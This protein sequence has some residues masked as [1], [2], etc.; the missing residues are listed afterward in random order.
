MVVV[1]LVGSAR[2]IVPVGVALLAML[3][4]ARVMVHPGMVDAIAV[5]AADSVAGGWPLLAPAVGALAADAPRV[6][7][8]M[9]TAAESTPTAAV[10]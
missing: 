5:A 6:G 3:G 9:A 1:V 2:T 4:L 7:R 10:R 8:E